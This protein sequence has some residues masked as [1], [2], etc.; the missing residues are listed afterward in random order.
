MDDRQ[1]NQSALLDA[2]YGAAITPRDYLEFGRVWDD[3]I[4]KL[5][6]EDAEASLRE[7][8]EAL[9]L[10]KHFNRAF[11]VFEKVRLGEQ[12]SLQGFL[13]S[14][15]YGGAVCKPNGQIIASNTSFHR[16]FE[17][18]PD[19]NLCAMGRQVSP[20]V[21]VG[22]KAFDENW[23]LVVDEQTAFRHYGDDGSQTVLIVERFNQA[24]F[25]TSSS[26][27]LI[28]IRSTKLEWSRQVDD[29][30]RS[31]FSL[32]EAEAQIARSLMAG[33]RS[34][35]IS[36]SRGSKKSTVRQQI[37]SV[38]E[39]TQTNTQA[40]LVA[41]LVSLHHLFG[42]RRH[43]ETK[44]T[45]HLDREDRIHET[46]V[47]QTPHWGTIDFE[48]YGR[49]SGRSVFFLH[50]QMS[51]A[52]PTPEMIDAMAKED[53]LVF[54]PR[55]PGV[56]QTSL[57]Q[58]DTDPKGFVGAFIA[59]LE[60][61]SVEF[62][63][64]VGQGMSGVAMVDWACQTP[65]FDGAV[66]TIDTGIP[67]TKREQFE[68]MPPVSKRI[69][70][71]VWDCPDLFYAPFAFASEAL[72]ASDE[73]EAAFMEDQ[74]KDI[75]HDFRLIKDPKFYD[76]ARTTMRDFMSTPKRSADELVYWMQDWTL[77]LSRAS[78]AGRLTV[79]QSEHHD[80][81]RFED[82]ESYFAQMPNVRVV[83]LDD[84]AQLCVFEKP[85]L[86][87]AEIVDSLARAGN[88]GGT[89]LLGSGN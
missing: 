61:Q 3:T 83:Q 65:S 23:L 74:F 20:L 52:V 31:R 71:T 22:G 42:T 48:I 13:D 15:A 1:R 24:S 75:A 68:H 84:C 50:S 49:P 33:Q 55:K 36:A 47:E 44:R 66:V 57:E 60:D 54:A 77:Q 26:D 5:V 10:R 88:H 76:L 38:L 64:L 28:L 4:L 14:Q 40:M 11:E 8:A 86:I 7:Q 56:G 67:F 89:G 34:D 85:D 18:G 62:S 45:I 27:S 35:E 78:E 46:V 9:D 16:Q 30:L 37:K 43:H 29:F 87:A 21:S 82:T 80:F 41:L 6:E 17:L 53:L 72:F 25:D 81:L 32:T 2:I 58:L 70:W 39:K 63:A 73:G 59:M 12:Q 79:L 19:D 69:F 51:S